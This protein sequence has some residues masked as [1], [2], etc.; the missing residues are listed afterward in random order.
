MAAL[1]LAALLR[2]CPGQFSCG[3]CLP[4][5]L[6]LP[7]HVLQWSAITELTQSAVDIASW[8]VLVRA[9]NLLT[10]FAR[11]T[12]PANACICRTTVQTN[13]GM[14]Q[15]VQVYPARVNTFLHVLHMISIR[16]VCL[17]VC[18]ACIRATWIMTDA[19]VL[20]MCWC[21]PSWHGYWPYQRAYIQSDTQWAIY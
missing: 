17:R 19:E 9:I 20:P 16:Y 4:A 5:H 18:N 15:L 7:L 11:A 21:R 10:D 6:I 12:C 1:A 2:S 3:A 14:F 13:W 8:L